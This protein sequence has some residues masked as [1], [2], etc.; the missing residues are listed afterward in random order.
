MDYKEELQ[1]TW[2]LVFVEWRLQKYNVINNIILLR[3]KIAKEKFCI[4]ENQLEDNTERYDYIKQINEIIKKYEDLAKKLDEDILEIKGKSGNYVIDWLVNE[5]VKAVV[6]NTNIHYQRKLKN[7]NTL[8]VD[9]EKRNNRICYLM[10]EYKN[11]N[12]SIDYEDIRN[13]FTT[14]EKEDRTEYNVLE[15]T[16]FYD[17]KQGVRVEKA[18]HGTTLANAKNIIEMG[19]ML[20]KQFDLTY[21]ADELFNRNKIFFTDNLE[22]SITYAKRFNYNDKHIIFEFSMK[23]IELYERKHIVAERAGNLYFINAKE[24]EIEKNIL[25]IYLIENDEI[26][27]ITIEDMFKFENKDADDYFKKTTLKIIENK[28]AISK[29]KEV[30][31]KKVVDIAKFKNISIEEAKNLAKKTLAENGLSENLIDE[32]FDEYTDDKQFNNMNEH[33][34]YLK[35]NKLYEEDKE[36]KEYKEDIKYSNINNVWHGTSMENAKNILKEGYFKGLNN[37]NSIDYNKVFF[38]N[39]IDYTKMYGV[40]GGIKTSEELLNDFYIIFEV[41]LSNYRTYHYYNDIEFIV[42]GTVDAKDIVNIYLAK[43]LNVITKLTKEELMRL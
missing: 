35:E 29:A 38:S 4:F 16:L 28:K 40:V 18:Y 12:E 30:T 3:C 26:K 8:Y 23:D 31:R 25:K 17:L 34:E 15:Q 22:D 33:L 9:R 11:G 27:E 7:D 21:T 24:L 1:K 37:Y 20:P 42:W 10:Q 13:N 32:S 5:F 41:D 36:Y 39:S 14:T 19:K 6:D 2:D 43:G